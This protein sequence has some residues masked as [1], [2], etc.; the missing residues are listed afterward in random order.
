MAAVQHG[1]HYQPIN[2]KQKKQ[3]G[4]Q[5]KSISRTILSSILQWVHVVVALVGNK[6]LNHKPLK[7]QRELRSPSSFCT[8]CTD[9]PRRLVT[10][11]TAEKAKDSEN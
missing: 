8:L 4:Y 9:V 6:M 1:V 2:T 3:K 10:R 11:S 7:A 5:V